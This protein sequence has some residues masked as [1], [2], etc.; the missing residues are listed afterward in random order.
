MTD[1]DPIKEPKNKFL[2]KKPLYWY[3]GKDGEGGD[4]VP[5][6]YLG[7]NTAIPVF[8][9]GKE[10]EIIPRLTNRNLEYVTLYAIGEDSRAYRIMNTRH[11]L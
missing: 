10:Y 6:G 1:I 4:L 9:A 8:I 3:P 5:I 11:K 2:C 7:E